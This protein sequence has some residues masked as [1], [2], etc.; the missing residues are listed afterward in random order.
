MYSLNITSLNI[1]FYLEVEEQHILRA[2]STPFLARFSWWFYCIRPQNL[3]RVMTH[4]SES[5]S[6]SESAY[7]ISAVHSSAGVNQ[8]TPEPD[9]F[10]A[11]I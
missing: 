3:G 11:H 8:K 2:V 9:I 7:F 5:K 6:W 10:A 1:R 4:D